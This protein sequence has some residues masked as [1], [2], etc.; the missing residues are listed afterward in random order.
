MQVLA[1]ECLINSGLNFELN[2]CDLF[3]LWFQVKEWDSNKELLLASNKSLAESNYKMEPKLTALKN[4]L[5]ERSAL[6]QALLEE[7]TEKRSLLG[8]SLPHL[9]SWVIFNF[10]PRS[11]LFC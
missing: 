9:N 8:S 4:V 11:E 2:P 3:L 6:A 10:I 7:L 1:K 5:V